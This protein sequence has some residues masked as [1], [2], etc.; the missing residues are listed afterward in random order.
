M[1]LSLWSSHRNLWS[2][3]IEGLLQPQDFLTGQLIGF[4][5]TDLEGPR[6]NC[7]TLRGRTRKADSVTVL[8]D[9]IDA[10]NSSVC[11]DLRMQS[12]SHRIDMSVHSF[13]TKRQGSYFHAALV[14]SLGRGVTLRYGLMILKSGNISLAC[15]SLMV[16]CTITSSPGTQLIGVVT[17]CLSPVC[18]E[19]T[20][21]RTS[22]VFRPVEAG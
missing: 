10:A 15:S 13:Q 9:L 19:S 11:G 1:C 17:L 18:S 21:R 8:L 12:P 6:F 14:F 7:Y 20:M 5:E 22:A 16:G 2:P 3:P 4:W